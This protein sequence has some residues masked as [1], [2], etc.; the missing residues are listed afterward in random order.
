VDENFRNSS[1]T[2]RQLTT[3][4]YKG[5]F[6]CWQSML[7]LTSEI[8]N[9]DLIKCLE[10]VISNEKYYM[11]CNVAGEF[12][13]KNEKN[14]FKINANIDFSTLNSS[15]CN[16]IIQIMWKISEKLKTIIV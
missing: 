8:K 11:D 7:N 4:K 14:T 3:I 15:E 1:L 16:E 10:I 12:Q 9:S 6:E 2:L 13:I 5:D